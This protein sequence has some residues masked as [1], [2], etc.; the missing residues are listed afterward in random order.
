MV[1]LEHKIQAKYTF[2]HTGFSLTWKV[3]EMFLPRDVIYTSRTYAMMS[4]SVSLSMTEV[5]W[6]IIANLGF[7]FRSTFTALWSRCMPGRVEGSSRAIVIFEIEW[8]P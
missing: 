6:R 8:E 1:A 3:R 4:L 7:K 5:H 2:H